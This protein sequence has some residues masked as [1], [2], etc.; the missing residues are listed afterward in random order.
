VTPTRREQPPA[1]GR[2]CH[3]QSALPGDTSEIAGQV[4]AWFTE[5]ARDLPWRRPGTPAWSVLVSEVMLQQTPVARVLPVYRDWLARWPGPAELAADSPGAAVR[6]WGKLGYPRRAL[7]LH[8]CASAIVERHGGQVPAGLTELLALPGVG[9][10]TARAVQAFAFGARAAVVDTNVRRVL[11]RA[12]EGQGQAAPPSTSRDLAAMQAVLPQADSAAAV[13]CAAMMELGAVLCTA[14]SPSCS[15]C[16]IRDRC[17]WR[18]AG[19]PPYEGPVARPQRFAGTDR[20]VRG[21][22]LDVLRGAADPVPASALDAVWPEAGQ[23]RRALD[24]L[25][26]DGLVDPLPDGRFALPS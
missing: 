2:G 13:F 11:A 9:E 14:A 23:R 1:L 22:L 21:L 16:P 3:D 25:V 26:A 6:M 17:A 10:Y 4:T 7:R 20:Q 18:L 15:A 8:G 5:C 12:V 24:A 19:Y